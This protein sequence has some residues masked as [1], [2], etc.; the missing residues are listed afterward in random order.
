MTSYESW[1]QLYLPAAATLGDRWQ[2]KVVAITG[3][4]SGIGLATAIRA[5]LQ[6]AHVT[7]C[8]R[9]VAR[10]NEAATYIRAAIQRKDIHPCS[11]AYTQAD[12]RVPAQMQRWLQPHSIY[13]LVNC[14]GI[15]PQPRPLAQ[16]VFPPLDQIATPEYEGV[17]N[18]IYTDLLGSIFCTQAAIPHMERGGSIVCVSSIN[19]FIGAPGGADYAIA[20]SGVLG[21]VKSIAAEAR[22]MQQNI[23]V[24]AVAPGPVETPLL[25]NQK[26]ASMDD[27][28]FLKLASAG[29][30]QQRVARPAEVASVICFLGSARAS[31]VNATTINVDDGVLEE[32]M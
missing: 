28:T 20:K 19:A 16:I 25:M 24:N 15:A 17:E 14:A 18:A 13:L 8:G 11:I 5:A 22:E 3:G 6:G 30:I 7:V 29:T 10:W 1:R 21:L 2:G 26:P 12:V 27:D 32:R 31:Y 23:R 4:T 9:S